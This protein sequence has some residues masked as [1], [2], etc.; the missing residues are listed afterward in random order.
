M[1]FFPAQKPY[2]PPKAFRP[3]IL[4]PP[5][6][7]RDLRDL[8]AMLFPDAFLP[9]QK[10]CRHDAVHQSNYSRSNSAISAI[11]KP[12]IIGSSLSTVDWI[13]ARFFC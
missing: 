8:C 4:N 6:D 5:R 13:M 11:D 12:L 10:R 2:F 7:L 9:A 3:P 1:R